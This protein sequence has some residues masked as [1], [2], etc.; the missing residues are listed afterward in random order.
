MFSLSELV[1]LA[2]CS[3]TQVQTNEDI[4]VPRLLLCEMNGEDLVTGSCHYSNISWW[5]EKKAT[6]KQVLTIWGLQRK[7]DFQSIDRDMRSGLRPRF[8]C[9]IVCK[10]YDY[11]VT[12]EAIYL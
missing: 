5:E 9:K 7:G 1:D 12:F 10:Y 2:V 6:A 3:A 4:T 11:T 8:V